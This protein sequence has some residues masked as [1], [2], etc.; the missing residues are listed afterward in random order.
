MLKQYSDYKSLIVKISDGN[1]LKMKVCKCCFGNKEQ[2]AMF[3]VVSQSNVHFGLEN[4]F[5]ACPIGHAC[6]IAK[7]RVP[8][9]K[10]VHPCISDR[11]INELTYF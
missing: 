4:S 1:T 8:R 6:K 11:N 2:R 9:E 10:F 5:F 7:Y 3:L